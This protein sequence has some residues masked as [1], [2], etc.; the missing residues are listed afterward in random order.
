MGKQAELQ[1]QAL[2]D[3]MAR[4][5]RISAQT[6]PS[7]VERVSILLKCS[8]YM[9]GANA[10]T[11]LNLQ[12]TARAGK[13]EVGEARMGLVPARRN[14]QQGGMPDA[15]RAQEKV[16]RQELVRPEVPR[17]RNADTVIE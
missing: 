16:R 10:G 15:R 7:M 14:F 11:V 12:S 13:E 17:P 3:E 9:P 5:R 6:E 1:E 2:M 8:L 4:Q